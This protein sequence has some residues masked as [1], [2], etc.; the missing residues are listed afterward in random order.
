M[1]RPNRQGIHLATTIDT[2]KELAKNRSNDFESG[3]LY[4]II[5]DQINLHPVHFDLDPME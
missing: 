5:L 2:C 4:G 3:Y 1:L